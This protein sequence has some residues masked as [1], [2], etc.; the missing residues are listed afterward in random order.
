MS[1]EVSPGSVVAIV[2]STGAGKSTVC[3]LLTRILGYRGSISINGAELSSVQSGDL[4]RFMAIVPQDIF[5]FRGSVRFNL[6]FGE[7]ISD[8]KLE[9]ALRL[10]QAKD[11]VDSLPD[12]LDTEIGGGTDRIS[13]GQ[14]QLLA[15]ARAMARDADVVVLDEATAS[16]DPATEALIQAAIDKIFALKTVVVVAHRL[17]TIRAADLILVMERGRIV[18]RGNHDSLIALGGR[19]AELHRQ[20]DEDST[21]STSSDTPDEVSVPR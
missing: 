1:F 12:G 7:S 4:R 8:E 13:V 14:S 15:L 18:E 19:Y 9:S 3:R 21:V 2:G 17:S 10:M 6:A 16:V 11:L 5:M 20:M